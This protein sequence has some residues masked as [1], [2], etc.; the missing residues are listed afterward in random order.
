MR[1]SILSVTRPF[2]DLAVRRLDEAEFVD[3]GIGRHRVDQT[4]VRTFRRLDR[5]DAAVVRRMNVADFEAGAIAVE[6]AWPEGGETALVRQLG[7]RVRLI[8][9]LRQLASGRRSRG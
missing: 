3:P 1:Y 7:E 5:A 9:E 6:T 4:D 2:F 8:H